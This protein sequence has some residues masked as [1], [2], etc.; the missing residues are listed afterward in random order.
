MR[1]MLLIAGRRSLITNKSIGIAALGLAVQLMAGLPAMAQSAPAASQRPALMDRQREIAL[2]LSACPAPVASKAAVYVLEES[3]YVK[4][5][6]GENGFTAIVQHTLPTS[7]GPQCM[8]AEGARTMLPRMLKVAELQA[9]GKSREE[10]KRFMADASAKGLFQPPSRPGVNYMLSTENLVPNEKGVPVPFPPHVMVYAPYLTNTAIGVGPDL[11]P[12]GNFVGPAT[13]ALEGTP[14]ALIIIPVGT[15]ADPAHQMEPQTEREKEI[16]LALSACPAPVANKAGVY[17]RGETGYIKVRES[18][19][20]FTAITTFPAGQVAPLCMDAEGT[21]TSLVRVLKTAELRAQGK[22]PEE[23]K[24]FV[25]EAY[26]RGLFQP[27]SRAGVNYMLSPHNRLLNEKGQVVPFPSHVMVYAPYL[28]NADIGV[29]RELGPD[30]NLIGPA[31]VFAEGTPEA[32]IIVPVGP[33]SDA[34][35]QVHQH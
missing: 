6:D 13:V 24:R 30:G 15:P 32:M 5:R 14:Q 12:D 9:Q 28:T 19:N 20:G 23:I 33:S 26:A 31:T 2:A 21:R 4:V 35:R 22:S 10:I 25:G 17:V 27:P 29:G 11:G 7:Q 3:G 8:D 18:E 34:S 16:A 1:Y